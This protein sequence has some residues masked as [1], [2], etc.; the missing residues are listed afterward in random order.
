MSKKLSNIYDYMV[1]MYEYYMMGLYKNM[2]KDL[3]IQKH[4]IMTLLIN[5]RISQRHS[6]KYKQSN[7]KVGYV[8]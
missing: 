6:W 3:Q 7:E 8:S 2:M 5:P 1:M 4:N